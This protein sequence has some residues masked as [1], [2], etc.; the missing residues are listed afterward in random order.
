[1][2]DFGYFVAGIVFL[3]VISIIN[4]DKD[5]GEFLGM[6]SIASIILLI[7]VGIPF[8]VNSAVNEH[9]EILSK[10]YTQQN[11]ISMNSNMNLE[12]KFSSGFT[13]ASGK[14]KETLYYYIL[15]EEEL[16]YN[17]KKFEEQFGKIKIHGKEQ[18]QNIGFA[19]S[20][21]DFN[22]GKKE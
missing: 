3:L 21:P 8:M 15:A 12:G 14:V 5:W 19:A 22:E 4:G 16:G 7:F 1:M 2:I 11:I 10:N 6:L 18:P 13:F 17:I 9:V 20:G